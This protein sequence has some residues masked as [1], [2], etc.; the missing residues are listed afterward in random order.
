[1]DMARLGVAVAGV[2]GAGVSVRTLR[3]AVAL[4]PDTPFAARSGLLADTSEAARRDALRSIPF[5]RLSRGR[6][7]PRSIRCWPTSASFAGCQPRCRL[8]P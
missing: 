4:P 6:P 3:A 5:D 2:V 8:R 7:A 1:M